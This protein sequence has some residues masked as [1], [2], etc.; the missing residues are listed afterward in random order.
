[1][2]GEKITTASNEEEQEEAF[3]TEKMLPEPQVWDT[4][5]LDEDKQRKE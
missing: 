1:M 5:G 4:E 2:K 3:R